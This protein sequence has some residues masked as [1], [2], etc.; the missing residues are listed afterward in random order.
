MISINREQQSGVVG[1]IRFYRLG[2]WLVGGSISRF[3][4]ELYLVRWVIIYRPVAR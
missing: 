3:G 1:P 4:V 2:S